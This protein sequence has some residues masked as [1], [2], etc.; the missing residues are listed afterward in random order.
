MKSPKWSSAGWVAAI[1][2]TAVAVSSC[3]TEKL[4][5]RDGFSFTTPPT[6]AANF[7]GYS[8]PT[9]KATVCG[10]CHAAQQNKWLGTGHAKAWA[11]LQASGHANK[12]CEN[13]HTV[14]MLGNGGTDPNVAF[15]STKDPRYQDVQCES[16]HGAGLPHVAGPALSNRPL[17]S[18]AVDKSDTP[19]DGCG[20]CHTGTHEPFVDEWKQSAHAG[21]RSAPLDDY[22]A[23]E[24]ET[25]CANCHIG[26]RA[27]VAWGVNTDY[28]EKNFTKET[29]VGITCAVCHDP[30]NAGDDKQL[31][32]SL[33]AADTSKNLCMRCHQRRG[34]P[35]ATSSRGPHS[36]EG[37]TLLGIAGYRPAN[38][39]N[40][41]A[42]IVATH[43]SPTANSK[44]CATCHVARFTVNDPK[45]GGFMFQAT[46]HLFTAIPCLDSV[47][48]PTT[49]SC[50]DDQR[51]FKACAASG[52]HGTGDV[53]KSAMYTAEQR[54]Q[55]LGTTLNAQLVK[56]KAQFPG[57]Y[58]TTDN[59]ITTAEGATFNLAMAGAWNKTTGVFDVNVGAV[60]HNPF[61]IETLLT[62]SIKQLTTDYGVPT[63]N[64]V[65]LNNVLKAPPGMK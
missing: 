54:I 33:S 44:M 40:A 59:K 9:T 41:P 4:V 27:L 63:A 60:V 15:A 30:H 23:A 16:C 24:P 8:D 19:S 43:G 61:L 21:I 64:V 1:A 25:D 34:V 52:C 7:V 14:S 36:P 6:A 17:A 46:G 50:S 35:A 26:Q 31:R 56:V 51:T 57:E 18:I 22:F 55:T 29:A 38:M 62:N 39:A 48:R 53:A 42:A 3:T 28:K 65:N 58:S 2:F 47:G 45:T 13:C 32:L 11:N 49:A 20:E 37:P 12:D 10:S 5:Y